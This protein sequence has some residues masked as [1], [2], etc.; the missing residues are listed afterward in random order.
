MHD[1]DDPCTLRVR[2]AGVELE[3]RC[4]ASLAPALRELLSPWSCEV[5]VA[6]DRPALHVI[7]APGCPE[8]HALRHDAGTTVSPL[9]LEQLLVG[10][11]NWIDTEV[12]SRATGLTP[13]HAGAVSWLDQVILL[14]GP[15]GAGKSS[16][17]AALVRDGAGY[18]SDELALV[19][20]E[21][22]VHPYP[23][24]LTLRDARGDSRCIVAVEPHA[25]TP[26]PV[27][28]ILAWRFEQDAAVSAIPIS[29]S[30]AV[31]L[32]LANSPR[33]LR[34]DSGV[35]RGVIKAAAA[36]AYRGTRGDAR[37]ASV[38]AR[39]LLGEPHART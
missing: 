28:L 30:D 18:Y 19:D 17:V 16:L 3:V 6:S 10:V 14:P 36:P 27:G 29:A 33:P 34:R 12:A 4:P 8:R 9:T 13:I 20:E 32:L 39:R 5:V 23:R 25:A 37:A 15:S 35:P 11:Q 7:P 24:P 26:L 1:A 31:L 2:P 22:R 38:L 21:G